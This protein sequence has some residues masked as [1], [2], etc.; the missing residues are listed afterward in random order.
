MPT[1]IAAGKNGGIIIVKT[2]INFVKISGTVISLIYYGSVITNPITARIP[3]LNIN[4]NESAKNLN[5]V[6]LG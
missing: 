6:G 4:F 2:S 5:L 3:I 1:V